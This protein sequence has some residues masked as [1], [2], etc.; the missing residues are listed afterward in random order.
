M[1]SSKFS[2][3]TATFS[4]IT[5]MFIGDA[6]KGVSRI[7]ESSFK[8]ALCFWWRALYFNEFIKKYDNLNTVLKELRKAEQRIFGGQNNS[9]VVSISIRA[10][11][12]LEMTKTGVKLSSGGEPVGAGARYLGYGLMV[13]MGPTA[14][15][16]ERSC[17]N[18]NQSFTVTLV[19]RP[20][21]DER[22]KQQVV[23]ALKLFGLVGGLGS[24][25]RRG[26]GSVAL[27]ALE[28]IQ[29]E[30]LPPT[31]LQ[32][33][34][35]KLKNIIQ[36]NRY[37]DQSGENWPVTAFA[38]ESEIHIAE[39]SNTS[40]FSALNTIGNELQ[41][42]RSW[43]FSNKGTIYP[44]KVNGNPSEMNFK[45]DHDL[46]RDN[47][48]RK[49]YKDFVPE[50]TA[51][52]LP[53]N[54]SRFDNDNINGPGDI[55]RRASPLMFHMHTAGQTTLG[56]MLLLPTQFLPQNRVTVRGHMKAYD[57]HEKG[58]NVL[59]HFLTG[60]PRSRKVA[61]GKE[62]PFGNGPYLNNLTRIL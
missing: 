54:Y 2:K 5:P 42:Y 11:T 28:G 12:K 53:H 16:L 41:R 48:F 31:N 52:G 39:F 9:S 46:F 8:G 47:S 35:T 37:L 30:W 33:Y 4:I 36:D 32:D 58:I 1:Q 56:V 38:S 22:D 27:K 3:V 25:V 44:P 34:Q 49:K 26:Y 6:D 20:K 50:R 62:Q 51:F 55:D 17:F 24:R 29:E 15:Q 59:K 60:N 13:A 61:N 10:G 18:S 23:N 19:F 57:F 21:Y 45:D 14:G 40:P 7:R 43:G